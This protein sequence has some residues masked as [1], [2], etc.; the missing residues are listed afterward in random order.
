M[1]TPAVIGKTKVIIGSVGHNSSFTKLCI[2]ALLLEVDFG[3]CEKNLRA[4]LPL[5]LGDPKC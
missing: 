5:I 3:S 4:I 2:T 1:I